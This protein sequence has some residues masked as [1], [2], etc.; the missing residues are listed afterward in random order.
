MR[1]RENVAT[2]GLG[3]G[4]IQ[5]WVPRND[6]QMFCVASASSIGGMTMCSTDV[7]QRVVCVEGVGEPKSGGSVLIS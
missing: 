6:F 4:T 2:R 3:L 7:V 5:V 1:H